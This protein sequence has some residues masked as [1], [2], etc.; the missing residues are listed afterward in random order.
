MDAWCCY[1][2]DD[3]PCEHAPGHYDCGPSRR[4]LDEPGAANGL[5]GS[6]APAA[7]NEADAL[8]DPNGD[9]SK[10]TAVHQRDGGHWQEGGRRCSLPLAPTHFAP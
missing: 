9:L 6:L 1:F 5:R 7:R 8:F 10:P 2:V 3:M 4:G